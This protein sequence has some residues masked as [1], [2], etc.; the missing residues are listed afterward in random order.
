MRRAVI[1]LLVC[2]CRP[3]LEVRTSIVVAPRVLAVRAEPAEAPPG[4]AVMYSILVASQ[5][6]TL[7]AAPAE[8]AFCTSPKPLTE[9]DVVGADCLDGAALAFGYGPTVTG[10]VPASAC[11]LFGPD[12]PP[13][14]FRPRDPDPTG[15]YYQP[16]RALA[17]GAPTIALSRLT[18]NLGD[19]PADVAAD[20]GRRYRAN[21]NPTFHVDVPAPLARGARVV[22]RARWKADDAE[23][24]VSFDRDTQTL[25][26][27][28]EAMRV[29][30]FASAGGFDADRTGRAEDDPALQSE[31]GWTAPDAPGTVHLWFVLRDSRGGVAW[32]ERDAEVK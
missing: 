2:A 12:P 4:T 13:G 6:G 29:S 17:T 19:A 1:F 20:F 15:G 31:N 11:Q 7:G 22:L 23:A 5:A 14:G 10:K 21:A 30:W 25:R 8:W 3:D 28:R 16:V 9:N 18:C 27:R 26:D 24:Y 32:V